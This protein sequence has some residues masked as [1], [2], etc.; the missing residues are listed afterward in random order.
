MKLLMLQGLP[1]SGKTTLAKELEKGGW[2]RVNKDDIRSELE[3]GGWKWSQENEKQVEGIR[4]S[5]IR[6]GLELGRNVVS[7]DTNFARKHRV[8][9]EELARNAKAEFEIQRID[10]PIAECIKRDAQRTGKGFVGEKVI[11]DM[12]NRYHLFEEEPTFKTVEK[13][14]YGLPSAV[15]CDLDGTLALFHGKRSPYDAS[16]CEA[17][18]V[19]LPVV[20]IISAYEVYHLADILYVSGREDKYREPTERWLKKNLLPTGPLFMRKTGD[21]RK[22]WIVKG[23][24]FDAHI[25]GKYN[26]E[27]CLDDRN[28]VVD[29]W[30][31]IGLTCLQVAPGDF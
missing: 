24:I 26:V 21:H 19:N 25:R 5:R 8:R 11:R 23:E 6:L 1:G 31:S 28:Q 7:D 22:D 17:D 10:T 4:D 30:R 14:T 18:D 13:Y 15:I 27:F 20:G 3:G 12:A 29:F 16:T 2:L 9:L